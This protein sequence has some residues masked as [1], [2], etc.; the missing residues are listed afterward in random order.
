MAEL[1]QSQSDQTVYSVFQPRVSFDTFP[2][3]SSP[4]IADI[5]SF[6]LAKKH[7]DYVFTKRS[8]T[9]LCGLDANDYSEYALEWLIDEL[10]DDG[11]EVVCLRVID[12][13]SEV[14][15]GGSRKGEAK[16]REEAETLMRSIEARNRENK[17][18]NLVLEFAVGKVEKMFTR[19]V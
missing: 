5:T 6:T 8:R 15:T 14:A 2:R 18:V 19:M 10:V 1:L 3:P 11:D 17:A 13:N 4:D 9:F 16:Y 7:K 12:P